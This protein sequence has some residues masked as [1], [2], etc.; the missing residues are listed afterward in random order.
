MRYEMER[1]PLGKIKPNPHRDLERYK[2]DEEKV[3]ELVASINTT[4]FWPQV[5]ARESPN[6]DGMYELAFGHHRDA[7]LRRLYDDY[8]EEVFLVGDLDESEMIRVMGAENLESFSH[9]AAV[10]AE[11]V[12]AVVLAYA[13]GVIELEEPTAVSAGGRRRCAPSFI[14]GDLA[15]TRSLAYTSKTIQ[16]FLGWNDDSSIQNALFILEAEEREMFD[17]GAMDGMSLQ[18]ARVLA[19]AARRAEE[20]IRTAADA[21][22]QSGNV[23]GAKKL[24]KE[25]NGFAKKTTKKVAD[26]VRTG[27]ETGNYTEDGGIRANQIPEAAAKEADEVIAKHAKPKVDIEKKILSINKWIHSFT[28]STEQQQLDFFIE[29]RNYLKEDERDLM[30][31]ELTR[32]RNLADA[33]IQQLAE[34]ELNDDVIDAEFAEVKALG[35][36]S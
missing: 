15:A 34:M 17:A 3:A 6:D 13:D 30:V 16:S 1:I 25:A 11:T 4:G 27:K 18:P 23:E 10:T 36:G 26:R 14:C 35:D 20:K 7:A 12:R 32:V 5:I 8:H 24:R 22:E 29:H 33:Y 9:N 31:E 2:I 28:N 21:E 19:T